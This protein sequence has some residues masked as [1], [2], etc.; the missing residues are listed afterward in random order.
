MHNGAGVIHTLLTQPIISHN[1]LFQLDTHE[2]RTL[3]RSYEHVSCAVPTIVHHRCHTSVCT[4]Y[5]LPQLQ[6]GI[7]AHNANPHAA[8]C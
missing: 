8:I 5:S 6:Q 2:C 7:T 1:G 3:D 4:C